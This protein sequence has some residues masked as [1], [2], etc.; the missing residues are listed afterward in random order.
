MERRPIPAVF[1]SLWAIMID[2]QT[3]MYNKFVRE[4]LSEFIGNV[5]PNTFYY[6]FDG[7]IFSALKQIYPASR[8][9]GTF[10]D[11]SNLLYSQA[12]ILV[13]ELRGQNNTDKLQ[14]FGKVL[15]LS[16]LPPGNIVEGLIITV[17][18]LSED[19]FNTF[20]PFLQYYLDEWVNKVG[21]SNLSFHNDTDA[22][23]NCSQIH[24]TRIQNIC[25]TQPNTWTLL[26]TI[27][28]L[29]SESSRD[30]KLAMS[31][32]RINKGTLPAGN[33]VE[34][35]KIQRLHRLFEGK[36][37]TI[38]EF[39]SRGTIVINNYIQDLAFKNPRART[40]FSIVDLVPIDHKLVM[41]WEQV[42]S[43]ERE[44]PLQLLDVGEENP[45]SGNE[46]DSSSGKLLLYL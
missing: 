41:T 46:S 4:G 27:I 8:S 19:L 1:P 21:V 20:K 17:K 22:I 10:Y 6:N 14:V 24:S 42:R 38:L 7:K 18:N 3:F 35:S 15:F 31:K 12:V 29:Q 23:S 5:Q 36:K 40:D 33:L 16:L 13:P 26:E 34:V 45:Q 44:I 28:H 37:I 2:K 39:I 32:K 11:H 9:K 30:I 43:L 25:G